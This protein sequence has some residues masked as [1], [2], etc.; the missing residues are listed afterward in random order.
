MKDNDK[1]DAGGR[2][3][4]P[5]SGTDRSMPRQRPGRVGRPPQGCTTSRPCTW[6]ER[7]AVARLAGGPGAGTA[8]PGSLLPGASSTT[9]WRA[10]RRLSRRG[11][12]LRC[13]KDKVLGTRPSTEPKLRQQPA[14]PGPLR[15]HGTVGRRRTA[16]SRRCG[17]ICPRA[18][19]G[20]PVAERERRRRRRDRLPP[21][22]AAACLTGLLLLRRTGTVQP[23]REAEQG[24]YEIGLR[25]GASWYGRRLAEA[26]S[27]S[28]SPTRPAVGDVVIGDRARSTTLVA[29]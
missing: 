23:Y 9:T 15:Q 14:G 19:P 29:E 24:R 6:D 7:G 8:A 2:D 20:A 5:C 13:S 28:P 25:A 26:T 12:E 21:V 4:P 27:A 22:R 18:E 10:P 16:T 11:W 17:G 3:L 1:P